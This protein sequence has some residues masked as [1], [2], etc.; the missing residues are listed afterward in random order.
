VRLIVRSWNIF[1]GRTV[2]A[3]GAVYVEEAVRLASTGAPDIVCLQEVPVWAV[4]HLSRWSGMQA[5]GRVAMPALGGPLARRLTDV[6]PRRLRSALTGQANALLV[7]PRIRVLET[8]Q[9]VLNPRSLRRSAAR[10]LG[11]PPS[12]RR[13]WGRD[14]RVAQIA[15]IAQG[16]D[17]A[18]VANLHLTT[19]YDSRPAGVELLRAVAALDEGAVTGEATILCGD[20]NLTPASSPELRRLREAGFSPPLPGI[21]QILVRGATLT[22][23]PQ[24]WPDDRRRHGHALLSD[25]A[26]L[27]AEMMTP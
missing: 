27:E 1:H 9:L 3:G 20:L 2:P 19:S 25:H 18:T 22:R 14:R 17:T 16:D 12:V 15:R 23:A 13:R 8:R 10:R 7:A 4:E 24:A 26:P 5:V 21:D 6:D 11:L